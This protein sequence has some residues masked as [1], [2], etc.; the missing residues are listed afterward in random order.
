MQFTKKAQQLNVVYINCT[1]S[2]PGE[3]SCIKHAEI[4]QYTSLYGKEFAQFT[5]DYR[6]SCMFNVRWLMNSSEFHIIAVEIQNLMKKRLLV[7]NEILPVVNEK[8]IV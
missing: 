8:Q 3:T 5:V 1:F 2:T 7:F 6:E 4:I